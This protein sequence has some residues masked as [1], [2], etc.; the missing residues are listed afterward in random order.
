MTTKCKKKKKE[1]NYVFTQS[2]PPYIYI[3]IYIHESV[4][5]THEM[6]CTK[7]NEENNHK[8]ISGL[9]GLLSLSFLHSNY[10]DIIL[11][12]KIIKDYVA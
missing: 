5:H 1:K 3:Y 4:T 11:Q 2:L 10:S 12:M 8:S 7:P 6:R 9:F